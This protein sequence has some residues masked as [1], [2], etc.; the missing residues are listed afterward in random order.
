M[1]LILLGPPGSGK[2]TQ[3][4]LIEKYIHIKKISP[5]DI[6]RNEIKKNSQFKKYIE[7]CQ[8]TGTLVNNTLLFN[9]IEKN[10]KNKKHILFDGFPR[11]LKQIKFL[12]K[13]NINI[14]YIINIIINTKI[15]LKR[16]KYRLINKKSE[17]VYNIIYKNSIIKNKDNTNGELLIIRNDDKY[18]IIQKR[19]INHK[20]NIQEIINYYTNKTN[21][22]IL[23]IDGDKEIY[24]IFKIIKKYITTKKL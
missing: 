9:L 16:L 23:N 20:I 13:K 3:A 15:I 8:N 18:D 24:Y 5:G 1:N 7:N 6:L 22:K 19:L 17:K 12:L 14:N 4:E 10:I 21:I 2:G 11:S